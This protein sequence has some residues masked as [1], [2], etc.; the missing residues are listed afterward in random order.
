MPRAI[1]QLSTTKAAISQHRQNKR[2][3]ETTASSQSRRGLDWMNFFIADVEE[4]FGAFIA[5]YLANLKWSEETVGLML[6]VGR[7][8]SAI[9]LIPG[10]ALT[11]AVRWKR[12][13]VAVSS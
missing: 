4:G 6:T 3:F 2:S 12:A 1:A 5:F 7:I 11:D 8:T 13:L 9:A 10:G